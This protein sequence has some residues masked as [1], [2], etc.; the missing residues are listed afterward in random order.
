MARETI[1]LDIDTQWDFAM[2]EGAD[3]VPGAYALV[4]NWERLTRTARQN[5]IQVIATTQINEALDPRFQPNGGEMAPFCVRGT[6][7]EKKVPA[8]KPRPGTVLELR[9][10]ST[11]ELERVVRDFREIVVETTGP[12]LLSHPG[13]EAL[14]KGTKQ[15]YLFGLFADQAVLKAARELRR[16]GLA[17]VLVTNATCTRSQEPEALEKAFVDMAALGVERR[18]TMEVMTRYAPAR[19]H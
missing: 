7:G 17:V 16:M 4:P 1:F 19:R 2:P 5:D 8:T 13:M 9:P 10:W 18:T 11:A 14:L 15:A 6:P 3:P 12:D